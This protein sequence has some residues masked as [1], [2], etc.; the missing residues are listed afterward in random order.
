[1]STPPRQGPPRLR[2][3]LPASGSC[4]AEESLDRF[5]AWVAD[6]GL[7]PYPA[8]EEALLELWA[9]R[10]VVLS[11]PTGSGKS[12][13]ALALHWKALC[14]GRRSFYTAPIKALAS[15]RPPAVRASP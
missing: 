4:S 15:E 8:Q 9:D 13:V 10:H 2:E 6:G 12:L 5:L 7:T 11:T 3:R 14:E 1:M